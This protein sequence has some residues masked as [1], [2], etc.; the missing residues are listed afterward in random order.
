M[1]RLFL[2]FLIPGGVFAQSKKLTMNDIFRSSV[3]NQQGVYGLNSMND[4]KSYA[5]IKYD[6]TSRGYVVARNNFSNGQQAEI[7]YS[8]SD[9]I[10]GKDTLDLSTNFNADESKVLI[11]RDEEPVYRRSSIANYFV[12]DIKAK[13]LIKVSDNGKQSFATFSPDGKMIAFVRNNNIFIKDLGNGGEKQITFDGLNNKIINGRT[14]WVYEEEF[15][16]AP[17]FFWS[18]DSKKI[19]F[20]RFDET[21][22]PEFSMTMYDGLYPTEYKYKYPKPGE[23]NSVVSI[24]IYGLES[25]RTNT[26]DVGKETDQYIPKVSWTNDPNT[27][28]VIRMNRH[29]NRQDYLLSDVS[30]KTRVIRTDT[31]PAYIQTET[32]RLTFLKK[33]KHFINLSEQDGYNHIYL[34]DLNGKIV[35]QLTKGAWDVTELYGVDEKN[36]LIYYQSAERSPLQRDIYCVTLNGSGKKLLSPQKGTNNA[37]FSSD[38]SY[39]ILNHNTVNEPSI[40]TLNDR[41]GKTI[42]TLEDNHSLKSRLSDFEIPATEFFTFNTSTGVS[43]NG[44][45]VKP[46]N[47][48]AQKKYP[49]LMYVYGGPG[50]Q[51]VADSWG[52]GRA[53]WNSYLAQQG[54]IVVSIDGR[55]TG[56][57]GAKFKKVTYKDLGNYELQDQIEGAKWLAKQHF[58]DAGRIGIWGWSFGG[59]MSSLCITK[60]AGIFKMAIAVAPVTSWR[61]YDSIYTER[62]LQTPQEN[63][64]GYDENSPINFAKNM[65]G[66]FL[67]VHGTGDDNVHFQNSVM[68]SEALIQADKQFDQAY[69]PNKNHGIY[70][71]NTTFQLYTRLTNYIMQNL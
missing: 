45:M 24:H 22:V 5:S 14:D 37:T 47:F 39:Y 38:Y 52:G 65:K 7:L 64:A 62:Y 71:G 69:Y 16:F 67:L 50:S 30:G 57:R 12:Y 36:G 31:D 23:K 48:D 46:A 19:A 8:R 10:Y 34:Y 18:P 51:T 17:A 27:L 61:F 49:V 59:Y 55:G 63:P 42:R 66:N 68:F 33:T 32:Q 4:G 1:N 44:S 60:G 35:R 56:Y 54:Y 70:G 53:K 2:L 13:K 9:L 43:L 11:A 58:V 20:Y 3:F 6:A 21:L 41:S 29:Q 25:G 40:I 15:E 26:V 28:C